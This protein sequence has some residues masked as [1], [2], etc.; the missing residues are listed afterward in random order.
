MSPYIEKRDQRRQQ[1]ESRRLALAAAA[2]AIRRLPD[3]PMIISALELA[4]GCARLVAALRSGPVVIVAKQAASG[5]PSLG[6]VALW[7]EAAAAMVGGDCP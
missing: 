6:D 4:G 3:L 7:A 2:S 1:A 5:C